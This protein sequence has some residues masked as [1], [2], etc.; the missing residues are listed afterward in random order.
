MS[1]VKS[2][3]FGSD[4]SVYAVLRS[5]FTPSLSMNKGPCSLTIA[6]SLG[7]K[8]FCIAPYKGEGE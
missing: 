6:K 5:G 2:S 4:D 8:V 1:A 7:P 3:V